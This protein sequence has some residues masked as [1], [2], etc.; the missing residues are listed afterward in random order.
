M[1]HRKALTRSQGRANKTAASK[2][3]QNSHG[4]QPYPPMCTIINIT[5]N[6]TE[7]RIARQLLLSVAILARGI[8]PKVHRIHV[9]SW[10]QCNACN[11]RWRGHLKADGNGEK[12]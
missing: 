1:T 3:A 4:A 6:G 2:S 12:Q 11:T 7:Q 8:S 10:N 5:I 9:A